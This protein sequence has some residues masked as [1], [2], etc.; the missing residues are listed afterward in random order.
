M[1]RQVETYLS[2]HQAGHPPYCNFISDH[3]IFDA[4]KF[5]PG[6]D[7]NVVSLYVTFS[8]VDEDGKGDYITL[9]G[10]GPGRTISKHDLGHFMVSCL[11]DDAHLYKLW[12][13]CDKPE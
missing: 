7:D 1:L 2:S 5:L 8:T 13:I 11:T 6:N 9:E 4:L 3:Y 10:S 12:G